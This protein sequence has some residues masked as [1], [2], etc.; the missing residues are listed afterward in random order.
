M[1]G[2]LAERRDRELP[3]SIA[4]LIDDALPEQIVLLAL[5]TVYAGIDLPGVAL[6][7]ARCKMLRL[8]PLLSHVVVWDEN[9]DKRTPDGDAVEP[10]WVTFTT[11]A[12]RLVIAQS[13]GQFGGLDWS[14]E[15]IRSER[16]YITAHAWRKDIP[17]RPGCSYEDS[18][19]LWVER[20]NKKA[21]KKERV[22]IPYDDARKKALARSG[23][24]ALRLAFAEFM[25]DLEDSEP[26]EPAVRAHEEAVDVAEVARAEQPSE[27]AVSEPS[28]APPPPHV[29]ADA[30]AL[31]LDE[32]E[33]DEEPDAGIGEGPDREAEPEEAPPEQL[34]GAYA[35]LWALVLE[36]IPQPRARKAWLAS[37]YR[38]WRVS[39]VAD[40]PPEQLPSIMENLRVAAQA[41][42]SGAEG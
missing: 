4:R 10:R 20:F 29:T 3:S 2:Q 38:R 6:A 1:S 41:V 25:P 31:P 33:P 9:K 13:S 26:D 21:R 16:V 27:G 14:D 12:G 19:P 15:Q 18:F 36:V 17:N 37:L 22:A 28:P 39:S 8:N 24:N 32:P 42:S 35:D 7:L 11:F 40:L 30:P 5:E 23:R 34:T